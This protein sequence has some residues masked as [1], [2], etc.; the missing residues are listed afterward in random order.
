MNTSIFGGRP[1]R[2]LALLAGGLTLVL[3]LGRRR[4]GPRRHHEW[5]LGEAE[6]VPARPGPPLRR[7]RSAFAK[8]IVG[9]SAVLGKGTSK[10]QDVLPALLASWCA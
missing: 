2:L 4:C 8:I 5:Y 1:V 10:G 6:E 3:S 7:R 9:L